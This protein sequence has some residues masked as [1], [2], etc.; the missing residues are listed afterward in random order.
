MI[1]LIEPVGHIIGDQVFDLT[2]GTD[3]NLDIQ[4][5]VLTQLL[6]LLRPVL[7][8]LPESPPVETV[9]GEGLS[10]ASRAT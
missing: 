10:L 8:N 4:K 1:L 7:H 9:N 3:Q 2:P 6:E 5:R